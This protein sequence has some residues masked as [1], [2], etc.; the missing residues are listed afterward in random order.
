MKLRTFAMLAGCALAGLPGT[1]RAQVEGP[2]IVRALTLG[3]RVGYDT[4]FSAF[5]AGAYVRLPLPKIPVELQSTADFTFLN[6][7]TERQVA[8]DVLWRS[9]VGVYVGG[10]PVFRNTV[11]VSDNPDDPRETR[12]GYSLV[13]G[14]GG[15]PTRDRWW[16]GGL[17]LRWARVEDFR[18]MT[19]MVEVGIP[20]FRY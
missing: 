9:G 3:P 19:I 12:T 8:V 10:G 6:K 4:E 2:P 11:F 15:T 20:L 14:L 13:I 17:E 5:V 18:P 16:I 7:I 1:V